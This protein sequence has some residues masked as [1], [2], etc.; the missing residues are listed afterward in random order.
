LQARG[1]IRSE[2]GVSE[3]NRKAKYYEL[4]A[5]GRRQLRKEVTSWTRFSEAVWKIVNAGEQPV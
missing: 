4:T 3:N 1:W 2:W 5:E